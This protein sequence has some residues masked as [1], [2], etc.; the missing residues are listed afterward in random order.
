[1]AS[2]KDIKI[3]ILPDDPSYVSHFYA[4]GAQPASGT[5]GYFGQFADSRPS[6]LLW[7]HTG[8]VP[9][10]LK[11]VTSATPVTLGPFS[12][13]DFFAAAA[14]SDP[15]DS[16]GDRFG[17]IVF[18]PTSAVNKVMVSNGSEGIAG[19]VVNVDSTSK[20]RFSSSTPTLKA[21]FTANTIN[22]NQI[23]VGCWCR[24][25]NTLYTV[26][27]LGKIA[28]ADAAAA[29]VAGTAYTQKIGRYE[30]ATLSFP[31]RIIEIIQG[32][33][34]P[35]GGFEAWSTQVQQ[36]VFDAIGQADSWELQPYTAGP[37]MDDD[38]NT[39]SH[40]YWDGRTIRDTKGNI[41]TENGLVP[42][43]QDGSFTV[44]PQTGGAGPYNATNNYQSRL[45]LMEWTGDWSV[46]VVFKATISGG[47]Q[48]IISKY[49]SINGW[50]G[51]ITPTGEVRTSIHDGSAKT[52]NSTTQI[53]ASAINVATFG[54]SGGTMYARVN[55]GAS[56]SLAGIGTMTS[57]AAYPVR[58][59]RY[60]PAG[61]EFV[62]GPIYEIISSTTPYSDALH[63]ARYAQVQAKL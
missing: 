55:A 17:A 62:T 22:A 50:Y 33:G 26:L 47:Y 41:W 42:R 21:A 37:L 8:S 52:V 9:S 7:S 24:S 32:L 63:A 53:T 44:V 19:Y 12:D 18:I 29:E 38:A 14:A 51:A 58:I 56:N 20:F 40:V 34:R 31:G 10:N 28:S 1:M 39:V 46:T 3:P 25:G 35:P 16:T 57:A 23:N 5:T 30:A 4:T 59:G 60:E 43:V 15:L 13:S 49:N 27:N 45:D 11:D 48:V 54:R 61:V 6:S 2:F 36:A